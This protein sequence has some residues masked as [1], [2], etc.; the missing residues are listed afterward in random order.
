MEPGSFAAHRLA[1]G[2]PSGGED[3]PYGDAFPH[4]AL[5]DQIGGVDFQKGCYVGQEV[6]SRMQHRGTARSRIVMISS[7]SDLP[8]TGTDILAGGRA[9]GKIGSS[10]GK[11]GLAMLRLDRAR[12]ALDAGQALLA[13]NNPIVARI[14]D[15]ANFGWP[16]DSAAD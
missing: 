12:A 2:M 16:V 1:L 5:M 10:V 9:C 4:E 8:P 3:F 7:R 11:A 13:G 15:W 14:Q 6:V